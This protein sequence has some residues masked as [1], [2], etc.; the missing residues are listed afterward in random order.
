MITIMITITIVV[1]AL[2]GPDSFCFFGWA[3]EELPASRGDHRAS[4]R[5]RSMKSGCLELL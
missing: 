3:I 2:M 1:L 5:W 4:I